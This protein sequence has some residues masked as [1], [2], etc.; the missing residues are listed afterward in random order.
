MRVEHHFILKLPDMQNWIVYSRVAI[1][2]ESYEFSRKFT[3]LDIFGEPRVVETGSWDQ[4]LSSLAST[5]RFWI[6]LSRVWR[7]GVVTFSGRPSPKRSCSGGS[8]LDL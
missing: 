6:S 3:L 4:L 8:D 7:S 5:I 1:E 2:G